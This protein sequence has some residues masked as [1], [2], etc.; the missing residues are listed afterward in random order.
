MFQIIFVA[1]AVTG[2]YVVHKAHVFRNKRPLT[3]L[4]N[5]MVEAKDVI[6]DK[7]TE[8]KDVIAERWNS[9]MSSTENK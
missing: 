1:G 6:A 8:A 7:A 4:K 3:K 5:K 2:G 9:L